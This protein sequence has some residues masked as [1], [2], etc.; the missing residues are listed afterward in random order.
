M[1]Y[2]S[3]IKIKILAG[4]LL[5]DFK[6]PHRIYTY[7]HVHLPHIVLVQGFKRVAIFTDNLYAYILFYKFQCYIMNAFPLT[8]ERLADYTDD[9]RKDAPLAYTM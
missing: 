8:I 4:L 6:T 3:H 5:G 1:S 9:K 2:G 7:T